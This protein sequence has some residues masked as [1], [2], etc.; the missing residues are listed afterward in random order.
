MRYQYVAKPLHVLATHVDASQIGKAIE[1][2][3]QPITRFRVLR[4]R[5]GKATQE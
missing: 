3:A 2:R 4:A 1:E 5:A